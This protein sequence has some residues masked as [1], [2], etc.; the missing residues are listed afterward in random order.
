[1]LHICRMCGWPTTAQTVALTSTFSYSTSAS[2]CTSHPPPSSYYMYGLIVSEAS[3]FHL[4]IVP[5]SH[6]TQSERRGAPVSCALH[7]LVAMSQFAA[8]PY[9][10]RLFLFPYSILFRFICPLSSLIRFL[11]RLWPL[12]LSTILSDCT[13]VL[14]SPSSCTDQISRIG[15]VPVA[16]LSTRSVGGSFDK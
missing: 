9:S 12:S 6:Q 1:M 8:E 2:R 4:L 7:S 5:R 14:T 11:S 13:P 3:I 10:R 15:S 16:N